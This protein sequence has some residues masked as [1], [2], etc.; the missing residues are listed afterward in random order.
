MNIPPEVLGYASC[1]TTVEDAEIPLARQLIELIR[2]GETT[3][4]DPALQ[5][6]MV[7]HLSD[8]Q[9]IKLIKI[10]RTVAI[11]D[12]TLRTPPPPSSP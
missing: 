3:V 11:A 2:A 8:G 7:D 6:W 4:A 9:P 5:A 12:A 1:V 10:L